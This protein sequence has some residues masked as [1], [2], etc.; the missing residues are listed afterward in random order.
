VFTDGADNPQN[1]K[2]NNMSFMDIM[3]RAQRADVMVYAIGLESRGYPGGGGGFGGGGI[4]GGGFGGG[5]RPD[6]GLPSIAAET[7]GGYFELRRAEELASTFA[8]VAEELHRQYLIGFEPEKLDGKM[9]KL[10]VKVKTPGAKV[11]ARKEYQASR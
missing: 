6:P 5:N 8:R 10:E 1:F 4:G 7:G 11:R 2:L 9:H 3:L